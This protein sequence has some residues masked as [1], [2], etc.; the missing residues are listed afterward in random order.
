MAH[1]EHGGRAFQGLEHF[2]VGGEHNRGEDKAPEGVAA[3]YV[4]SNLYSWARQS[5]TDCSD[6]YQLNNWHRYK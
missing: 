5:Y 1:G 2:W 3:A 4:I 6:L